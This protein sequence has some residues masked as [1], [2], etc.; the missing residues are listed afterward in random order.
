[1]AEDG[2]GSR[3]ALSPLWGSGGGEQW[4]SRLM[5]VRRYIVV[6]EKNVNLGTLA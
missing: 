4:L 6:L 3:D 2:H 5:D 1:M